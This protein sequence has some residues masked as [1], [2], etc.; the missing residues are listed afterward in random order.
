MDSSRMFCGP[1]TLL[2]IL[3]AVLQIIATAV[4]NKHCSFG[5]ACCVSENPMRVDENNQVGVVINNITINTPP[6][7]IADP[8]EVPDVAINGS[9][10]VL[11]KSIDYENLMNPVLIFTLNCGDPPEP[12]PLFIEI[13]NVNDNP[14]KFPQKVLNYSIGELFPVNTVWV[15]ETASDPDK[16]QVYY[17]LDPN[18]NGAKYFKLQSDTTP[19]IILQKPLD[20]EKTK[21]LQ[22]IL[23]A[24]ETPAGPPNDTLTINI[25]VLDEDNKPPEFEPCFEVLAST[26]SICLNAVYMGNIT[27]GETETGPL[28]LEPQQIQAV[29]GDKEIK[30]VIQYKMVNGIKDYE[31]T[32]KIDQNTGEITMIKP[33][34]SRNPVVLT[35]MAYQENDH[36]KYSMTT[37]TL[38]VL[39][40]NKCPPQFTKAVYNGNI[41]ENLEPGSIVFEQSSS[42]KPLTVRAEDCDFPDKTNPS[43][44]Y[45]ITPSDDFTINRDGFIFTKTKLVSRLYDLLITATDDEHG[46]TVTTT[47]KVQVTSNDVP[48]TVTTITQGTGP[49]EPVGT[50]TTTITA[51]TPSKTPPTAPVTVKTTTH[52]NGTPKPPT[53]PS[54]TGASTP[55]KTPPRPPGSTTAKPP[56]HGSD[57]TATTTVKTTTPHGNGTPKPPT[58]P[59]GTGPTSPSKVPPGTPQG[60]TTTKPAGPGPTSTKPQVSGL[61]T[62]NNPE[63]PGSITPSRKPPDGPGTT[64]TT[65]VKTTTPHGNG[66]P[67]PPTKPPG[68]GPTSPSKVPPG[69]PQ[70]STTTKPAGPGPTSTKPQVSGSIT[71]NNPEPP[72]SITPSR[73]PP[74]GPGTTSSPAV[75]PRLKYEAKHMAALG[76]PLAI[77]LIICF[78]IIGI[79]LHKIHRGKMEWEKLQDGSVN[80]FSRG[81][82][83]SHSDKLQFENE[84]YLEEAKSEGTKKS[85]WPRWKNPPIFESA[86]LAT[87]LDPPMENSKPTGSSEIQSATMSQSYSTVQENDKVQHSPEEIENDTEVKS[88]LTKERKSDEGYKAVWF[89]EDIEPEANEEHVIERHDDGEEGEESDLDPDNRNKD[90]SVLKLKSDDED[91]ITL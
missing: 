5:N 6:I 4:A 85:S 8:S 71:T 70:G 2:F 68:T 52:G 13:H 24:M 14:P 91:S 78:I 75:N 19:E 51:K 41:Q 27:Q 61:I 54:G 43:I 34:T 45:K 21:S 38:N 50:G 60:S 56:G 64:T 84:G 36:Y 26:A 48:I 30:A 17:S 39:K 35:V 32:F 7:T 44:K 59:P 82:I 67:K 12:L 31:N 83:T 72:G 29:D 53:K 90:G 9:K 76:V 55:S 74:D 86:G 23:H 81:S 77:L 57:A 58:K 15:K 69:T 18:T 88:I 62:T 40:E 16:G 66:T 63:P 33:V 89:K 49:T 22:L 87:I 73:K 28:Q 11:T 10:L 3:F 80:K 25:N 46:Q 79:L 37:V 65:T 42:T 1:C 47:V 20:Y